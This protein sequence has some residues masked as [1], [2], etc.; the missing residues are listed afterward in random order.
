MTN[1]AQPVRLFQRLK[2]SIDRNVSVGCF[3]VGAVGACLIAKVHN[4]R[5]TSAF[6]LAIRR[7]AL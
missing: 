2:N 5:Q 3:P 7:F 1:T 4:K 6:I